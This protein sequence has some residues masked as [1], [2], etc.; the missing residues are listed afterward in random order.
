M[1]KVEADQPA[2]VLHLPRGGTGRAA[3]RPHAGPG[4]L[5]Q[6]GHVT[7]VHVGPLRDLL[8]RQAEFPSTS[9]G[10]VPEV[11]PIGDRG[12]LMSHR[13]APR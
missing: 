10:P 13:A 5:L 6:V 4:V 12:S 3:V 7:R 8:P 9:G 2:D 1:L 11:A